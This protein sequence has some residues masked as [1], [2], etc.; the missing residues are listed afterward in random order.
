MVR[1]SA[2]KLLPLIAGCEPLKAEHASSVDHRAP[3]HNHARESYQMAL[4]NF[5]AF[6]Q[7]SVVTEIAQKPVQLPQ[8]FRGAVKAGTE[9]FPGEGFRLEHLKYQEVRRF[10]A[11]SA[12]LNPLDSTQKQSIREIALCGPI[13]LANSWDMTLHAALPP[14]RE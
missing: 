8:H 10:L 5:I 3:G 2:E 13:C 4:V 12:V 1:K 9:S 7:F 14:T 11:V 6:Q